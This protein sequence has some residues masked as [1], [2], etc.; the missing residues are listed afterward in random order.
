LKD[1]EKKFQ[2][3]L[4]EEVPKVTAHRRGAESAEF[5]YIKLSLCVLC[6]SAVNPKK[7]TEFLNFSHFYPPLE[8]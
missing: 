2:V 5:F 8:D 6:V 1:R 7:W 4:K 3:A